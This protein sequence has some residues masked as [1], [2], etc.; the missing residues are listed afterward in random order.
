MVTKP[1]GSELWITHNDKY[2]GK[3]IYIIA[4][5]RTSLQFHKIKQETIYLESGV[6]RITIGKKTYLLSPGNVY[7]I[8]PGVVHRIEATGDCHIIEFSTPELD[9]VVRLEDDYDR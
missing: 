5:H 3:K 6:G 9:D 2:A 8:K 4:G 1:W 7:E